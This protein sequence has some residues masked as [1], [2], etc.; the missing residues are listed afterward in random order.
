M[1]LPDTVAETLADARVADCVQSSSHHHTSG[2]RRCN[3]IALSSVRRS[4]I[5]AQLP[6]VVWLPSSFRSES[7][8][9]LG[10]GALG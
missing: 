6:G 3:R 7:R 1:R 5:Q 2:M 10:C 4:S 9:C 8:P